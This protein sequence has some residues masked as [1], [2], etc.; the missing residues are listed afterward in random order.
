MTRARDLADQ[1]DGII[2]GDL[3]VDGGTIKLDGNYPVGT[4]NVALGDTALDSNVSG[5]NNTA[6]GSKALTANTASDNTAVGTEA[7]AATTSG[8]ANSIVGKRAFYTNTTGSNNSVL[9]AFS[10]F[11]NTSGGSNTAVGT[12]ALQSNTVGASNTAV[13][14]QAGYSSTEATHIVALGY[15]AAYSNT[16]QT[17]IAVGFQAGYTQTGGNPGSNV[18][19][20]VQTNYSNVSGGANTIV[21]HQAGYYN[22]AAYNTYIGYG[23]GS[24]MTTG[25]KNTIIGKYNGNEGGLDIRTSS[26]NIVL[27]DG[28]GNPRVRIDSSGYIYSPS[29]YGL[30]TGSGANMFIAGDGSFQRS[31]SSLR[32][33]NT[34]TDAT[35]GLK[36]LLTLRPVTYKGNNDGDTLFGGLIAEEVHAVGLT[37]FVQYNEEN[38][39]DSLSYSNMVSL[40]VKAIQEQQATITALTAR[41]TALEGN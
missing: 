35:H 14:Y 12:S 4:D 5:V 3:N 31:T 16:V 15:Q 40:C 1:A 30:T 38:Q 9:G 32:Y 39:P 33:K 25:G 10:L 23:A 28:D 19:I 13:G 8:T 36:E 17:V 41:I 18:L 37:E 2:V 27:S 29:T 24:Q 26:N 11:H 21:G 6:V 7:A 22:T 20:G 34:I